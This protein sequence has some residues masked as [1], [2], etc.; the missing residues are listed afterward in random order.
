MNS[1]PRLQIA[2]VNPATESIKVGPRRQSAIRPDSAP[3]RCQI[4][5]HR[6]LV[7][8]L[9]VTFDDQGHPSDLHFRPTSVEKVTRLAF[10]WGGR[11]FA[12]PLPQ[13]VIVKPENPLHLALGHLKLLDRFGN[14]VLGAGK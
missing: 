14:T 4:W 2:R 1:K 6:R 12:Y 3:V 11:V 13:P 8:V 7:K 9:P 10:V 5:D